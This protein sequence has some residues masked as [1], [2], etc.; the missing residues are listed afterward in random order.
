MKV[1]SSLKS[2]K[3]RPGCKIVRRHGVVYVI[4]KTNPRF[5]ARQ[6]G[7]KKG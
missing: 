3:N 6:G 7:K 2:A 5:K 1:L 4:S